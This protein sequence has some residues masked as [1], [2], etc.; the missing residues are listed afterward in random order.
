MRAFSII[1]AFALVSAGE[2]EPSLRASSISSLFLLYSCSC[3][4]TICRPWLQDVVLSSMF[5]FAIQ[6]SIIHLTSSNYSLLSLSPLLFPSLCQNPSSRL[7][8]EDVEGTAHEAFPLRYLTHH[9]THDPR[10]LIP[11]SFCHHLHP[12]HRTRRVLLPNPASSPS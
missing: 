12:N 4:F 2:I 11:Q 1:S 5:F 8:R 6:A 3:A 9:T 7:R 10:E